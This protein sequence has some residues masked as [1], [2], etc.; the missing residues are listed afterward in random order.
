[1]TAST[2]KFDARADEYAVQSRI[3]LA[4]YDA[5][6]ELAACLLAARLGR[7]RH[8]RLLVAGA[9]GTAQE[10]LTTARLAP[11][12]RYTAVDPSGPMLDAARANVAAAGLDARVDFH[13]GRVEDLPARG[14]FDAATLIGV[15]HHLPGSEAKRAVLAAL[16]AR[17]EPGAPLILAGNR[18]VYASHPLFLSAWSERWRL[19][20][21]DDAEVEAKLGK[22]LHAA[23]PPA[24]DAAVAALLAGSGFEAAEMFFSSLFWGAWIALRAA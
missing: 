1:M 17:L 6:H 9:G 11:H 13:V 19:H 22:I 10:I 18:G 8:A 16:A 2:S 15:L 12:W 21:A 20:G 3:A 24:S 7:G 14:R 5:C 4:G 23:E